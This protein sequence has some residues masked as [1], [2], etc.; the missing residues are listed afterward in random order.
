MIA[1]MVCTFHIRQIAFDVR[2]QCRSLDGGCLLAQFVFGNT[3][4]P[5]A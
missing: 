3:H 1:S 2:P 4:F 5:F